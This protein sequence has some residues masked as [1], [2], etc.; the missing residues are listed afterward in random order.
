MLGEL[1]AFATAKGVKVNPA[2]NE[3][4]LSRATTIVVVWEAFNTESCQRIEDLI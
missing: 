2:G 3:P 4:D 1:P